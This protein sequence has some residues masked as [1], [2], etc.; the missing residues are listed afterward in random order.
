MGTG[1]LSSM[2]V[3]ATATGTGNAKADGTLGRMAKALCVKIRRFEVVELSRDGR[4]GSK[5]CRSL[6][7]EQMR[8]VT[9]TSH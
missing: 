4:L 6:C 8:W 3:G 5:G 1:S 2:D 7:D 9:A